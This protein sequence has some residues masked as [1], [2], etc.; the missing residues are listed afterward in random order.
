MLERGI[1]LSESEGERLVQDVAKFL[2]RKAPG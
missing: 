1:A 2:L